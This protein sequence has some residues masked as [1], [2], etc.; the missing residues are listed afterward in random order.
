MG[1]IIR[2]IVTITTTETW[3]LVWL[4]DADHAVDAKRQPLSHPATVLPNTQNLKEEPD[5]TL[6]ATLTATP[7]QPSAREPPPPTSPATVLDPPPD[8]VSTCATAGRHH[9]RARGRRTTDN[10][11]SS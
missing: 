5:E 10:P 7:D 11:Q 6:Q 8:S 4:P 3:T 1:K 2:L 9:K